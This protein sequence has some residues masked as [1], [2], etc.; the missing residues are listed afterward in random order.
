MLHKEAVTPGTL[1]LLIEGI[2]FASLEDIAA[3]KLNAV[4]G[5]GTRLKDFVDIAYLS[6]Y[7]SFD[8]MIDAYQKK[9]QTRNPLIIIKALSFFEEINFKEPLHIIIGIY[10]WKSVEKRINQMIK[11]PPKTFPPFS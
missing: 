9:Y 7:L 1:E 5:N 6:S 8:Q 10:K 11:S 4:I 3:M 2:R